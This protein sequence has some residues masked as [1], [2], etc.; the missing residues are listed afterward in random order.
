MADQKGATATNPQTGEKLLFDGKDWILI[1][2]RPE[3]PPE[4]QRG[5][6]SEMV[7]FEV[8]PARFRA[9]FR[10]NI[11]NQ[12]PV[13]IQMLLE[14]AMGVGGTALGAAGGTALGGPGVGTAAGAS[15]GGTIGE[16]I[17]Q[18][19]GLSPRSNFAIGASG[20]APLVGVGTGKTLQLGRR[21]TAGAARRTPPVKAA[22]S[23]AKLQ[24]LTNDAGSLGTRVLSGQTG[25]M[26]KSADVLFRA[27]RQKNAAI[28]RDDLVGTQKALSSLKA[29]IQDFLD[30]PEAQQILAVIDRIETNLLGTRVINQGAPQAP[31]RE[32]TV[33]TLGRIR[34]LI[35]AAIGNFERTRGV[36][37]GAAKRLFAGMSDDMD[38]L[39][40]SPL[41]KGTAATIRKAAGQR[42][43]VEFA[44][45]DLEGIIAK[46]TSEL[47]EQGATVINAKQVINELIALTNTKHP[48]FDKNF[49]SALEKELPKIK[50]FFAE[51]AKLGSGTGSVAG[52][53]SIVVR[54]ISANIGRG[55]AAATL[56]V[57]GFAQGN[58]LTGGLGALAGV[59]LPEIIV[60]LLMTPTGRQIMARTARIGKGELN[61][62]RWAVLMQI[63]NSTIKASEQK[64]RKRLTLEVAQD[65]T[66]SIEDTVKAAMG[67]R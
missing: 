37:L 58:A 17:S 65:P 43:K 10:H 1:P 19:I 5:P 57:I 55:A 36:K 26:R 39:A 30:F 48:R 2:F 45:R 62:Q 6:I 15:I 4:P 50:E 53:G 14:N 24:E 67:N 29:E 49:T 32:I 23:L 16:T 46:A 64:L 11:E 27:A 44:T 18:E 7:G 21:L 61:S 20:T 28:T 40:K 22:E 54:G 41:V 60:G 8:V 3:G 38:N 13:P 47:P 31:I 51:M 66:T 34:S 42:A 59:A 12:A 33:G 25:P 56:G 9:S 35:G 63:L 52:P